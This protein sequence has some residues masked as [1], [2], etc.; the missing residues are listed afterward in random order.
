MR[1]LQPQ[2][3]APAGRQPEHQRPPH[4]DRRLDPPLPKAAEP[5]APALRRRHP[6]LLQ[7]HRPP[8]P[9][10]HQRGPGRLS[11]GGAR[12]RSPRSALHHR[13]PLLRPPERRLHNPDLLGHQPARIRV[14]RR[15]PQ[16]PRRLHPHRIEPSAQGP[17]LGRHLRRPRRR[18]RTP[19]RPRPGRLRREACQSPA[20][21]PQAGTPASAAFHG[22]GNLKQA[23]QKNSCKGPAR[24]AQKLSGRAKR[25][26]HN[27]KRAAR[28]G[29]SAKAAAL[30][31]KAARLAKQAA[32][33]SKA[34]KRCH[35]R[36]R[37]NRKG[38]R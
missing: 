1:L 8:R 26:R 30:R 22:P 3:G 6:P 38:N 18:R 19:A 16:R 33:Q 5:P 29:Q 11:V 23:K 27:A 28:K 36:A 24:K 14:R 34:A 13:K 37:N 31:R 21:A 25:L 4:L 15:L 20:A 17:R 35:K 10:R 12:R 9:L 2:R 32:K 7:L